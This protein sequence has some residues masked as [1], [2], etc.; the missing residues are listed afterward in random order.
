MNNI[1][2]TLYLAVH[3]LCSFIQRIAYAFEGYS[4]AYHPHQIIILLVVALWLPSCQPVSL[5]ETPPGQPVFSTSGVRDLPTDGASWTSSPAAPTHTITPALSETNRVIPT[6]RLS[7]ST[8]LPQMK[9]ELFAF[10]GGGGPSCAFGPTQGNRPEV[11]ILTH[12][13][14][15]P[16]QDTILCLFNFPL[17]AEVNIE[18]FDPSGHSAGHGKYRVGSQLFEGEY[19]SG[20]EFSLL[21]IP[22]SFPLTLPAGAWRVQASSNGAQAEGTFFIGVY[23]P[24]SSESQPG[25]PIVTHSPLL[26]ATDYTPLN[27]RLRA[28]Y[29]AGDTLRVQG[30]HFEPMTQFRAGLYQGWDRLSLVTSFVVTTDQQGSF[31]HDLRLGMDLPSGEYSIIPFPIVEE[32]S[33]SEDY[34]AR[35]YVQNGPTR[36]L[37]E[38]DCQKE[39][40]L[41]VGG[42]AYLADQ[43]ANN[44]RLVPGF[45]GLILGKLQS[46]ERVVLLDGPICVDGYVWWDVHS[47]DTNLV[48]WTAEGDD[49][50]TWILPLP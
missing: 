7:T 24:V 20:Q 6:D 35:F 47:L 48:G 43:E 44:L 31:T 21:E 45:D 4:P 18:M 36:P 26:P 23:E 50:E 16:A 13:F 3:S 25:T 28:P 10:F 5:P 39:T 12:G 14:P 2:Q 15:T 30:A 1:T 42:W 11:Q 41:M 34:F 46:G 40:R 19:A 38:F 9:A 8:D 29:Q 27:P 33:V 37:V 49:K 32:E 22:I 17:D